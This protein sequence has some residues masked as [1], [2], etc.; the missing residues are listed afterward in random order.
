M[1]CS[2]LLRQILTLLI[3]FSVS[4]CATV[5]LTGR[6]QLSLVPE[7]DVISLSLT[8]YD[9]FI[10]S[11]KLSTD[12]NKIAMV[13]RVGERISKAV[14]TYMATA[15]L[16]QNLNGYKWEFN[17]IEDQTINAWCMSGG[18]VVVYTGLMPVA[19]DENG[20]ATVLGHEISHAV[21]R[22]GS[23]RMSNQ[24]LLQMGSTAL[25]TAMASKPA[26]TRNIVMTAFGIGSQVGVVLPFSRDNEYEADYMGLIFMAMAGYD[27]NLSVPFW[28]RMAKQGGQKPPEFL[29]THPVDANRIAR[30]KEK[31]PDAMAYYNKSKTTK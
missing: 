5:P 8:E 4:G 31:M 21:A 7:S 26:E 30:L 15:G 2:K 18:K 23:E 14:E 12:K 3:L 10:K 6:H 27:P 11:N 20:L 19:L 9:K 29:S 16:S 24:M 28:E 25:S 17:L 22:H 1:T 13:K